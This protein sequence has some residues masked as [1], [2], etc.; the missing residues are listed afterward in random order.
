MLM[1]AAW[2]M[3]GMRHPA[4]VAKSQA[5]LDRN[6]NSHLRFPDK[7]DVLVPE[8]YRLDAEYWRKRFGQRD[9]V[10]DCG[11]G[12]QD[13]VAIQINRTFG[14]NTNV[15][16]IGDALVR[17]DFPY[18]HVS[19][20]RSADGRG[21]DAVFNPLADQV[22]LDKSVS[23]LSFRDKVR[24]WRLMHD[25]NLF[26]LPEEGSDVGTMID[27]TSGMVVICRNGLRYVFVRNLNGGQVEPQLKELM[28]FAPPKP[29]H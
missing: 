1:L 18:M 14:T 29:D 6:R 4:Y 21:N 11:R 20:Y 8:A 15:T 12:L 28:G 27:G 17:V 13:G 23:R 7:N 25:E 26:A 2:F 5:E 16:V 24:L 22:R 10:N 9:I 19:A 3:W